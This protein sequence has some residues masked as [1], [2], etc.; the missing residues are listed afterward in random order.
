[1][2]LV[3]ITS[4]AVEFLDQSPLNRVKEL[5]I[6]RIYDIPL[7]GAARADD[8]LFVK[9]KEPEVVGPHHLLPT[10]WL[11]GARAVLSYFLPYSWEIREA[12]RTPG[13]PAQKWLYGR[14]EGE[15]VNNALREHLAGQLRKAGHRAV[16]P[17][18]D[19]RYRVEN[20]R[21]NWS[22]RHAAYIAG[23]G[24]FGLSKSLI[25]EKG[26]AGRYGSV[27]TDADLEITPRPY[28][29]VY[30]YCNYCYACIPRCPSEAIREEGKNVLACSD[31]M[32]RE[33]RPRFA[34]RYGCGKC[35]TAVPC[36]DSIPG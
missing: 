16:V 24:T 18:L 33:I 13:L 10:A 22:E 32:D 27:I 23:L 9:L 20:K 12:N 34:P 8:P 6:E 7:V 4:L 35:Q 28:E 25:T 30:D 29:G 19:S 1:M 17:P 5:G 31:Y 26:C 15:A 14:I 3:A 11:P 36:E 21:S 2:N